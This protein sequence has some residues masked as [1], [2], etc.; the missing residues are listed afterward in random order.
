MTEAFFRD[1][2]ASRESEEVMKTSRI[3]A[4]EAGSIDNH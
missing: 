4:L 3:D 2:D 1:A